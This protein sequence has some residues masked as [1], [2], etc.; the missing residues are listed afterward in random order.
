LCHTILDQL[1]GQTKHHTR[2]H[3]RT[4]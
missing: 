1:F 2:Q 4:T 3:V